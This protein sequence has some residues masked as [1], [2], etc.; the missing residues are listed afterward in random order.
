MRQPLRRQELR[1]GAVGRPVAM[2]AQITRR[3][4]AAPLA[5]HPAGVGF[6]SKEAAVAFGAS[7]GLKHSQNVLPHPP[8]LT[9]PDR[10]FRRR[11]PDGR[12]AGV[13]GPAPRGLP[14]GAR[15]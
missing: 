12:G 15:H 11:A 2:G 3:H 5:T 4:R 13:D 14:R 9:P 10:R 1:A 7:L 8:P 6:A